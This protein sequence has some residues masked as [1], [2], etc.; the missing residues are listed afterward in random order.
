MRRISFVVLMLAAA[1]PFRV[2][3]QQLAFLDR[4]LKDT[5]A[6]ARADT[7]DA[8]RQYYLGLRHWKDHHWKQADSLLRL[9]VQL[10]PWYADAYYAL[11]YLPYSRRSQLADEENRDH[12]PADWRPAVDEAHEFFRRAFRIN[13]LLNLSVMGVAYEI[14]EPKV[15]D[16]TDPAYQYYAKYWAWFVDLGLGRYRSAHDRLTTLAQREWDEDKHPDRVPDGILFFRG[17]AAAHT[18]Q[19]DKATRD[20]S[21]LLGRVERVQQERIVRVPLDDND[22]RFVL[23]TVHRLAG[24]PDSA[25]A[26]YQQALE[27]DLGLVMAHTNLANIYEDANRPADAMLERKRAAEVDRDDPIILFDLAASLFNAGQLADADEPLRRAIKLNARYS[28]SYYLLGRVTEELGLQEEARDHYKAF[29]ARA[30]LSSADLR[31]DATQRLEK[32][33]K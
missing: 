5:E 19:Y 11:Y 16:Y 4:S 30:P 33:P 20:F 17:L 29:L 23:A 28:P 6:W 14:E 7:N 13:P 31:A 12:I 15:S 9:S 32:L 24:H 10:D 2:Q 3:A 27:H 18:M 22:Y 21:R 1:L 25:V 8:R 26:L